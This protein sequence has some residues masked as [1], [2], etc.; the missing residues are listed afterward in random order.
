M[1]KDKAI[2]V[3][4]HKYKDEPNTS[5]YKDVSKRKKIILSLERI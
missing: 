3:C 1:M 4:K 5:F 2:I